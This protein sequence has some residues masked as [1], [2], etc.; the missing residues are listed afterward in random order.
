MTGVSENQYV[1]VGLGNPGREYTMTRHNMGYLV[2]QSIA[3]AL[4]W[5]IKE[6][7]HFIA[8]VT[9]GNIEGKTIHLLLPLTY[10][11]ES[12]QSLRRY[13]DFY[14]LAPKHVIV[15]TDD[16]DLEF[17]QLRVRNTGGHGGHNGLKSI[18]AHLQTQHYTRLRMGIGRKQ[19]HGTLADY[20]LETFSSEEK[21]SLPKIIHEGEKVLQRL[22]SEEVT[23]VMNTVN[24]RKDGETTQTA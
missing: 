18:Q 2:V 7:K 21:E 12:G 23:V 5:A 1:I 14:K 16:V 19:Q 17:G 8:Y 3:H 11:N 4:G 24:R 20:V 13:L 9:K 15:V 22:I 6:D 10:M